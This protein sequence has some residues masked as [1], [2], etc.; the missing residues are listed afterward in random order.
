MRS[1]VLKPLW[2]FHISIQITAISDLG[3][4]L[5]TWGQKTRTI[6]L[7]MCVHWM[8]FSTMSDVMGYQSLHKCKEYPKSWDMTCTVGILDL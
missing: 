4:V 7:K 3:D 5:F 6:S 2:V 8:T 1:S